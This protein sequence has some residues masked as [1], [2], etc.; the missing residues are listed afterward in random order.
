M[1]IIIYLLNHAA[2]WF[3]TILSIFAIVGAILA[4]GGGEDAYRA[5]DRKSKWTWVGMLAASALAL[6]LPFSFLPWIGAVVTGVYWFDVR[7]Q[8]KAIVNG[9]YSY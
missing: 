5:G 4:S 2:G 1:D 8:L 3:F 6:N 7:P 9:D